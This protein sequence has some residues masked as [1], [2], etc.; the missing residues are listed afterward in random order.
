[1]KLDGLR[2]IVA[3][4]ATGGAG[5]A[6]LL[7]NA[8][9]RV[10]LLERVADPRAVGA[11]IAL[12]ENGL[13]VLEGL[14]FGEALA[15]VGTPIAGVRVCDARGRTLMEPPVLGP[16]R[17]MR[18]RML[19]RSELNAMLLD[20]VRAHPN[21]EGRFG[22]ELREAREDGR[23]VAVDG[24]AEQSLTADLVVGADGVRSRVREGGDFGA[25][26][27]PAGLARNEEAWTPAGLFGSF[28]LPDGTYFYASMG[29]AAARAA[30]ASR[31]LPALRA[32]WAGAYPPAG[33]ILDAVERFDALLVNDVARVRCRR[34]V[35][36]RLA[37]VG[38]AAHAMPPN[39]GQGANSALVDGAVLVDSLRREATLD[40]ALAAY[41]ARRRPAVTRVAD[42]A[43]RLGALAERT[44]PV[45]RW[46]RDRVLLPVASRF[47]GPAAARAVLQERPEALAAMA[48]A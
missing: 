37:L 18:A 17:P 16:G 10:T 36:G 12:A 39:L 38:D 8:G 43:A 1:M 31:D 29:A 34:F 15:R 40:A 19:R 30:L 47:T 42:T 11:G 33:V 21:I 2:V 27:A 48:R 28:A 3:G 26:L 13:A 14:G 20:A 4:G 35:A 7:A 5:A 9:A 46:L 45:E 24:G 22:V 25:R 32:A 44:H 23:V 6:L 41:D